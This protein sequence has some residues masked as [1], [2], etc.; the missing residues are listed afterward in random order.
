MIEAV[1]YRSG[2]PPV[3]HRFFGLPVDPRIRIHLEDG[4]AHVVREAQIN[5]SRF[6]HIY[7]DAFDCQGLAECVN[8]HDFFVA[9]KAL[10]HP[11]GIMA[12]NLWGTQ[13]DSFRESRRLLD[14][15]FPGRIFRLDIPGRG[16]VIAMSPGETWAM[17][18]LHHITERAR[19]LEIET[20]IEY[21][22]LAR[23]IRLPQSLMF[24]V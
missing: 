20:G 1:E 6:D 11:N 19:L 21:S 5:R 15:Y 3:A 13:A 10:L 12:I 22:R 23:L 17:P 9:C 14:L 4:R 2:V 8:R 18:K 24:G 7:I 16:N